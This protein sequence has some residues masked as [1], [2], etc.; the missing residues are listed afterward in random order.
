MI[1]IP[2]ARL[3]RMM[4]AL[5]YASVEA[6]SEANAVFGPITEDAFGELEGMFQIFIQE[7]AQQAEQQELIIAQAQ[8]IRSLSAPIIDVW[9]DIVTL[10]VVGVVD[11]T[12]A[13]EMTERLLERVVATRARCVIIDITGV[14]Q[15]EAATMAHFVQM[16]GAVR[17]LGSFCVLTGVS[18]DVASDMVNHQVSL[19]GIKVLRS[20]KD[21]LA[22]CLRSLAARSKQPQ[23]E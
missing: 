17:L 6:F 9:D 4:H 23:Q 7:R 8:A 18:P 20:L 15:V 19:E 16:I 1:T 14:E 5:A 3:E 22:V 21:G 11:A 12:R 2:K 10:P 13:M